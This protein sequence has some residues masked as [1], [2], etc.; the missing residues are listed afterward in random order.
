[1]IFCASGGAA[2]LREWSHSE[3]FRLLLAYLTPSFEPAPSDDRSLG[4]LRQITSSSY[5]DRS[6]ISKGL[7]WSIAAAN[8][9]S[10]I[11]DRP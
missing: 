8:P 3:E 10:I 1:M 5:L 6:P 4:G 9:G 7:T 2:A 11:S